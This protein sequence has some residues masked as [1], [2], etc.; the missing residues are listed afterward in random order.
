MNTLSNFASWADIFISALEGARAIQ[1]FDLKELSAHVQA[2][3]CCCIALQLPPVDTGAGPSELQ[4]LALVVFFDPATSASTLP[5]L[6]VVT[7]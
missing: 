2:A 6:V 4:Q 5:A 1:N 7:L 3:C